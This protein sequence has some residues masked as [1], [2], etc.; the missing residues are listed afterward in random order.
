[1]DIEYKL[2]NPTDINYIMQ[3]AS[4]IIKGVDVEN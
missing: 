1:M 2:R 3:G 4:C